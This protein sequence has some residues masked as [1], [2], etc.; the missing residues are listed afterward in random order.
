MT[1]R[2]LFATLAAAIAGRRAADAKELVTASRYVGGIHCACGEPLP[3]FDRCSEHP[4]VL[5]RR[6]SRIWH[7]H[8]PYGPTIQFIGAAQTFDDDFL[9]GPAIHF[10]RMA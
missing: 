2:S 8:D 10:G 9:V 7:L 5:C 1:R 4:M 3:A 6:C